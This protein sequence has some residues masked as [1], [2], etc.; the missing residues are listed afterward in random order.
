MQDFVDS[1]AGGQGSYSRL[2]HENIAAAVTCRT[3]KGISQLK[4]TVIQPI[5]KV[6]ILRWKIHLLR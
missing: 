6:D 3:V 4:I 5:G 2:G 1:P